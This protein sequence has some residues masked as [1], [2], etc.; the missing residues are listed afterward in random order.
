MEQNDHRDNKIKFMKKITDLVK[1][2][3]PEI[4]GIIL[5]AAV[6]F[7]YNYFIGC[8][9][10]K[11]PI[12]KDPWSSTIFGATLGGVIGYFLNKKKK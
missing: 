6:G 3:V 1:R 8:S 5:G 9:T 12:V 2:S 7:L 11:C 4:I 10:G